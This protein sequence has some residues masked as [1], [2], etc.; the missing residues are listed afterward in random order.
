VKKR[1]RSKASLD[2]LFGQL[3][4][5]PAFRILPLTFEIASEVTALGPSLRDPMDRVIVPTARIH[6]LCLVTSDQ[7]I[8][9]SK[10]VAVIE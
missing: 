10:L 8:I 7:R 2:E 4:A 5:N 1:L 3:Q 9:E 6:R